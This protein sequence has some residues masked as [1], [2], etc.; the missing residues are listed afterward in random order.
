[1]S[2]RQASLAGAA[3]IAAPFALMPLFL[4]PE[5]ALGLSAIAVLVWLACRSVAY[6]IAIAGVPPIF[7]GIFAENP[8]PQGAVTIA[9]GA[10]VALAIAVAVQRS[11]EIPPPAVLMGVPLVLTLLLL[12]LLVLRQPAGPETNYGELKTEFFLATNVVFLVGGIFVGWSRE[13]LRILLLGTLLVSVAGAVILV[14]YVAAGGTRSILPVGLTFSDGDHSIS[15]GRQMAVGIILAAGIT[16]SRQDAATRV[17]AAAALPVLLAALIASGARGPVVGLIAGVTALIALGLQD[18][19]ARRRLVTVAVAAAAAFALVQVVVPA[20]SVVRSF[21]FASTDV[22][23]TSSGRTE[24]WAQAIRIIRQHPALGIGTG[25]FAD[26]NPPMIY[27]HNMVLEVGVELGIA[28]VL[29][30]LALLAHAVTR[31]ARAYLRAGH[32]DRVTVAVVLALFLAAVTNAM[33]SYALH[34]NWEVWLWAGVG[35]ALAARHLR[36][37]SRALPQPQQ[38]CSPPAACSPGPKALK[39]RFEAVVDSGHHA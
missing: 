3:A 24:M 2:A 35:T 29:L 20:T 36:G 18:R 27:P 7:F 28:G 17:L 32:D 25:G 14:V 8:L 21:S 6:P 26:V 13:R 33:L 4:R 15:M 19:V 31:M 38:K 11:E 37:E 12:C 23:G 30:L 1:M 22:E 16:L 10:A 39:Q 5:V 9:L 34:A